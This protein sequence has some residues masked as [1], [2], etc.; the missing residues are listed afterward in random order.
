MK[1]LWI[2]SNISK[3]CI[4][5]CRKL[6]NSKSFKFFSSFRNYLHY[7]Q[8]LSLSS[9]LSAFFLSSSSFK[10]FM[11]LWIK[12]K[13]SPL[14]HTIFKT[15]FILQDSHRFL[16]AIHGHVSLFVWHRGCTCISIVFSQ[17]LKPFSNVPEWSRNLLSLRKM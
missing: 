6:K 12:R 2:L 16:V 8:I 10:L 15:V 1:N 13:E 11:E 5:L 4:F 9:Y 14:Y 3:I 7:L 17:N